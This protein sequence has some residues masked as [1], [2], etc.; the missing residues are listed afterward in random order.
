MALHGVR[1][2]MRPSESNPHTTR[3]VFLGEFSIE[4]GIR[5]WA[6]KNARAAGTYVFIGPVS[7]SA[8]ILHVEEVPTPRFRVV[9]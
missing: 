8:Y 3:A 4:N 7:G 5:N 6:E 1:V 2:F 9:D